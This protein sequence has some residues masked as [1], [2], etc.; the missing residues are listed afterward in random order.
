MSTRCPTGAQVRLLLGGKMSL[1]AALTAA[2]RISM[3]VLVLLR[4][5]KTTSR[6]HGR[7]P[8]LTQK[9]G[10][11]VTMALSQHM[12]LTQRKPIHAKDKKGAISG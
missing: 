12:V 8:V 6:S 7:T 4:T 2:V 3:Q 1:F 11:I 10:L 9:K 5:I